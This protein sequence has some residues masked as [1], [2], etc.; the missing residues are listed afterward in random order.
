MLKQIVIAS[1]V[2]CAVI[3]CSKHSRQTD[4]FVNISD[5]INSLLQK[6]QS[7]P[8][9]MALEAF[10][11]ANKALYLAGQKMFGQS[12]MLEI[13]YNLGKQ[14][15]RTGSYEL[16]MYCLNEAEKIVGN[17]FTEMAG[18]VFE[19][20]GEIALRQKKNDI[21][22][23]YHYKALEVR[24]SLADHNGRASSYLN[25]GT[26]YHQNKQYGKALE[27]YEKSLEFSDHFY[28]KTVIANCFD[29]IGRIWLEQ[30]QPEKAIEYFR[31]AEN[32]YT[33]N[34][35]VE[36]LSSLY[37]NIGMAYHST[38]DRVRAS[39]YFNMIPTLQNIHPATLA[40][41]N[42]NIGCFFNSNNLTDSAMLYYNKAL[43]TVEGSKLFD[44][45][46]LVLEKR[47]KLNALNQNF[48]EAYNDY[49]ASHVAYDNIINID[50]IKAFT[51][52]SMQYDFAVRQ[53]EQ[54]YQNRIQ[55]ML[56]IAL[57]MMA[58]LAGLVVLAL[59]RSYV[60]KKKAQEETA[61]SFYAAELIQKAT[62]PTKEYLNNILNEHFIYFKPLDIVSGDFYW[63]NK[64]NHF[65]I[66]AVADCTGHGVPG[67]ILSMLGI[68]SLN[69]IT[70]KMDILK[71]DVILNELRDEI[72]HTLNPKGSGENQRHGM[73]IALAVIDTQKH[74][75]EFSGA[76]NPFYL[77]S[78]EHLIE[79][80]G[81]RMPVGFHYKKDAFSAIRIKYNCGDIIYM[82]SDGYADQFGGSNEE[83]P[84]KINYFKKHKAK[85][86][87][88][89]KFKNLLLANS[90][91]PLAEQIQI[92][93]EAHR[94]WKGNTPQTDDILIFG[95]RLTK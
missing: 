79:I 22:I 11:Y 41:A 53:Q 42:C 44:I 77:I 43:K 83:I 58:T 30:N 12:V 55:R 78:N 90:M 68:S 63:I 25:I 33:E 56:I 37:V 61:K 86:F 62:L 5:S 71:T 46:Y 40:E 91:K 49:V 80:K 75:I 84:G 89:K 29:N 93:D 73:N 21:A 34:H 54:L 31:Q 23:E 27:Y 20:I 19:K 59:Y 95:I 17:S 81:D 16:A 45:Q 24:T 13:Y 38:G 7:L 36:K 52:N 48:R 66:I 69:K 15:E 72:F 2:C 35:D 8:D 85:K 47:A 82:F 10:D 1:I 60:Q 70:A 18:N 88:A 92:I 32:I 67:A 94:L 9:S 14:S 39:N 50:K 57:S 74:E 3:G 76:H 64:V 26:V 4:I 51:E 28:S 65:I 87:K 6:S